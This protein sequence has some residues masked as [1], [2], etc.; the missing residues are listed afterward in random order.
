LS[1]DEKVNIRHQSF[2][3]SVQAFSSDILSSGSQSAGDA[4]VAPYAKY[5]NCVNRIRP[6]IANGLNLN[7][8]IDR[9]LEPSEN[10]TFFLGAMGGKIGFFTIR[11][12]EV[13][14]DDASAFR[15]AG[16][17]DYYYAV[18]LRKPD[19]SYEYYFVY[20]DQTDSRGSAATV[21]GDL[22]KRNPDVAFAEIGTEKSRIGRDEALNGILGELIPRLESM[23]KVKDT[24][25]K[26]LTPIRHIK[27]PKETAEEALCACVATGNPEIVNKVNE[28]SKRLGFEQLKCEE[29][30]VSRNWYRNFW[31]LLVNE[32]QASSRQKSG[33]SGTLTVKTA[34]M[35][36]LVKVN[37]QSAEFCNGEKLYKVEFTTGQISPLNKNCP[38]G[39]NRKLASS[40]KVNGAV[41]EDRIEFK[42]NK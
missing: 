28:V 6:P 2:G 21:G 32:A 9:K 8:D 13:T 14:F 19:G 39:A 16:Q 30:L 3:F 4:G 38:S 31:P 24:Y 40:L 29:P 33:L 17:G 5:L 12:T 25:D 10:P 20:A 15:R 7:A 41:K 34:D 36:R 18:R 37:D 22:D 27:W 23:P 42:P 35:P 11:P 1:Y 26:F